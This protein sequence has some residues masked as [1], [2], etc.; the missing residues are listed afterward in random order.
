MSQE[1]Q[2]RVPSWS[3]NREQPR[4]RLLRRFRRSLRRAPV[5][6]VLIAGAVVLGLPLAWL[7]SSSLKSNAMIFA[8]PPQWIPNPV[9]WSNFAT[10]WEK[11]PF[12]LYTLNTLHIVFFAVLGGTLSSAFVAFGFA[13]LRF[14]GRDALFLILLGTMMIPF[15]VTLIPT[16]VLYKFLKWLDT[17]KPFTWVPWFGGSAFSIFLIRQ[18]YMTLPLELDDAARIDGCNSFDIF[19]RIILPQS[20]P[21]LG[22]IAIFG[23]MGNWN[24]FILPLIFL[25]SPEKYPLALGIN[26]LRSAQFN[27]KWHLLMAASLM[28]C[29]PCI[30]LY[31]VAQRYFVQG[32]VFSG[33]EK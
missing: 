32:I 20:K 15:H 19:W 27:T 33:V 22:V 5:Y 23:F 29:V 7:V 11:V 8:Y 3:A 30:I 2:A 31:F 18:F 17:F 26:A 12:G 28:M 10:V 16:F 14:P 1:A 24:G 6:I 9:E 25:Q 4:G 13:R 21:A